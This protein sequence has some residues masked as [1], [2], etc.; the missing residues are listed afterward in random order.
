MPKNSSD[1]SNQ[2]KINEIP[3]PNFGGGEKCF[4]IRRG[5]A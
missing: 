3:P 2:L 1:I 5:F 4:D